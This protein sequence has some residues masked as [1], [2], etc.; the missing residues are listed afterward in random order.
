MITPSERRFLERVGKS[1]TARVRTSN[2]YQSILTLVERGYIAMVDADT[3]RLTDAGRA[4]LE[5]RARF[6]RYY[7][8]RGLLTLPGEDYES[9]WCMLPPHTSGDHLFPGGNRRPFAPPKDE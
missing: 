4:E 1:E 8:T 3:V 2:G 7:F 6:C 9:G 5:E